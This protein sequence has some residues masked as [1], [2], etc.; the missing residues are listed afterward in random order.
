[1]LPA[2]FLFVA[3][4]SSAMCLMMPPEDFAA[5]DWGSAERFD[6]GEALMLIQ[7]MMGVDDIASIPLSARGTITLW[8]LVIRDKVLLIRQVGP[9]TLCSDEPI[10][11]SQFETGKLRAL[12][13]SG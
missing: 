9:T 1:M 12:P 6:Q 8:A 5:L 11:R 7:G 2:P 3:T 13:R 10:D 4:P